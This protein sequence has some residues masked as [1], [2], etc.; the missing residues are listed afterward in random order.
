MHADELAA[1][2]A[3]A[4]MGPAPPGS[5]LTRMPDAWRK[6]AAV[7]GHTADDLFEPVAFVENLDT[8][9]QVSTTSEGLTRC[10]RARPA[11]TSSHLDVL[12]RRSWRVSRAML[13]VNAAGV[14]VRQQAAK[15]RGCCISGN[16]AGQVE[17]LSHGH[18]GRSNVVQHGAREGVAR[19]KAG[20]QRHRA[21]PAD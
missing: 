9:T 20:R 18:E 19:A 15:V 3:R 17:G 5:P 21:L 2:V 1:E 10:A 11:R 8:D 4:E 12:L 6:L 7:A 16:G 13:S 14:G